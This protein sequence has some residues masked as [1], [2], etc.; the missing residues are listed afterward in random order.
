MIVQPHLNASRLMWSGL[1]LC[2]QR[3]KK[4]KAPGTPDNSTPATPTPTPMAIDQPT[5]E[6]EKE[7]EGLGEWV[8]WQQAVVALEKA[9]VGLASLPGMGGA[10]GGE[11]H[12]GA[13]LS[14]YVPLASRE[15]NRTLEEALVQVSGR[16]KAVFEDH[17]RKREAGASGRDAAFFR[18]LQGAEATEPKA[19]VEG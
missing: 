13:R 14:R 8:T 3:G 15:V 10:G 6:D 4:R 7:E 16:R 12:G 18:R 19:P 11:E 9:G 1:L 2:A 5:P 17:Q